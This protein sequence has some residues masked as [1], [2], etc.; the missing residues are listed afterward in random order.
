[1]NKVMEDNFL[2]IRNCPWCTTYPSN[3][4]ASTLIVA[5][6]LFTVFL[7]LPQLLTLLFEFFPISL[8]PCFSNLASV[9]CSSFSAV[10]Y[11]ITV[12]LRFDFNFPHLC[13]CGNVPRI[14]WNHVHLK[15]LA[16]R[17]QFCQLNFNSRDTR[18]WRCWNCEQETTCWRNSVGSAASVGGLDRRILT[19][20]IICP[21][22]SQC[23]LTCWIL[24][25]VCFQD[26]L[27]SVC[28]S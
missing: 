8:A 1:M 11:S 22:P 12:P 19:W 15:K 16:L 10:C 2:V 21:F 13:T 18:N 28:W 25:A 9:K 26:S 17:N 5:A 27:K 6:G 4:L 23:Y 7:P 24:Q 14:S 3:I 20:N